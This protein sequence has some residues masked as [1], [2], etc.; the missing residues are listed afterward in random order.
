M[1][2]VIAGEFR[3][4]LNLPRCAWLFNR[5]VVGSDFVGC[6]GSRRFGDIVAG[7]LL[8]RLLHLTREEY[9]VEQAG[10]RSGSKI[11]FGEVEPRGINNFKDFPQA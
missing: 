7:V 2:N 1:P 9:S 10:R 8:S 4:A 11:L 6:T 5:R 3:S